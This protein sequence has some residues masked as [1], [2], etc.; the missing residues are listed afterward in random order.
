MLDTVC[1]TLDLHVLRNCGLQKLME[2]QLVASYSSLQ[3]CRASAQL[4]V[5]KANCRPAQRMGPVDANNW[6]AQRKF[7]GSQ[8][9]GGGGGARLVAAMLG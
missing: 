6:L 2:S 1:G 4:Q 3:A 9:K 5:V 7:K 8:R